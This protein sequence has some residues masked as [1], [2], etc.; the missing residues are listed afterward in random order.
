MTFWLNLLLIWSLHSAVA[1]DFA[2]VIDVA[3]ASDIDAASGTEKLAAGD[4]DVSDAAVVR[5][6]CSSL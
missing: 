1:N 5:S 2:L 6:C 3:A 4:H